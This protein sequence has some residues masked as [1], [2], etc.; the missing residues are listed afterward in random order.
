MAR[1]RAS[2]LPLNRVQR[3]YLTP[4]HA[5]L[6]AQ[7]RPNKP[8]AYCLKVLKSYN[9]QSAEWLMEVPQDGEPLQFYCS[10]CGHYLTVPQMAVV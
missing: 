9:P 5:A 10:A 1:A 3:P 2:E 6:Q 4:E 8:C 7:Y